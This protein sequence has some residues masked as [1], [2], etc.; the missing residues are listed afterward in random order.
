MN[1]KLVIGSGPNKSVITLTDKDYFASG[2]E[3]E[4]YVRGAQAFKMYHD[5]ARKMIPEKKMLEL[6]QI[7][8]PHIMLPQDVIYD[9][10]NGNP[11]GYT[12]KFVDN[13]DPI[14]RLFNRA[15]KIANNI[16][17]QQV[18]D[19]VKKLQLTLIS[20]HKAKCLAVDFNEL[21]V[22]IGL[23]NE[24]IPWFIDTDS[25]A[26]PSFESTA[27]MDSIRDRK[28]TVYDKQ[29]QMHY[30]P[31]VLSDWFSW[32]IISFWC[33][34]NIHPFRGRHPKYVPSQ[35]QKQMDDGISVFN[36]DVR[37]PPTVEDF[38]V[39][40]KRHLEWFKQVFEKGERGIPPL[41]DASVPL[42]TP[43]QIITITGT[44]KLTVEQ[45]GS[46]GS[47]IVWVRQIMGV[48]Y[49]VAKDAIYVDNNKVRPNDP[50]KKVRVCLADGGEMVAA[51][52]L[53]GIVEFSQLQTGTRIETI[54]SSD[55]FERNNAIYT[56]TNGALV[57]NTF[58]I[59][60]NKLVHRSKNVENVSSLATKVYSGCLI[61]DLLGKK[62][63]TLPY[64]LGKC[65]S[66]Y[67]PTMDKARIVDAK[68]DKTVT[69]ILGEI[70]GK[71]NRYVIVFDRNYEN[72]TFRMDEDVAPDPINFAVL[73]NGLCILLS[74]ADEI[75]LF[76]N[77]TQYETLKDPPFDA[78][79]PLFSTPRGFFFINGNTIHQIK[80]K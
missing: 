55:L 13:V 24:I 74:A 76:A 15:Y 41:A 3:A 78:S 72:F 17:P 22:L 18:A 80:R 5:P 28:A 8:D 71:Y 14:L 12:T 64:A 77:A 33:Y 42:L 63:L 10:K 4:I 79:M 39:I 62:Y 47:P 9:A 29:G 73:D 6:L 75:Q 40:P 59:L 48:N 45:V 19:L 58:S 56:V 30:R 50:G 49:I 44:D 11:L 38:G 68:S 57:E 34:I 53:G 54:K 69:V 36:K 65:F 21:N 66:K 51:T 25:Y 60:G 35:K 7:K 37:M 43:A 20:V 70:G 67:L 16:D 23:G 1:K 46:C 32:A 26:T 27:I 2:G 61:Q 31:S 52:R